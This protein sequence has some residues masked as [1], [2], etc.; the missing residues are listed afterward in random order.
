MVN[1]SLTVNLS[2]QEYT[3][4]GVSPNI[5]L[6]P[7]SYSD[8]D[9]VDLATI[10]DMFIL[11]SNGLSAA[12]TK[13]IDCPMK[14]VDGIVHVRLGFFAWPTIE[15]MSFNLSAAIGEIES[16]VAVER[17]KDFDVIFKL[18]DTAD[19]TYVMQDV[20]LDW[21]TPWFDA[22]GNFVSEPE[23]TVDGNIIR[24]SKPVFAVAR[25]TG[26]AKGF[27]A[28]NHMEFEKD[29]LDTKTT[30]VKSSVMASWTGDDNSTETSTLDLELPKC[31]S[32]AL[33]MCEGDGPPCGLTIT[34]NIPG[35]GPV[36]VYY[37]VCDGSILDVRLP[38]DVPFSWCADND[39]PDSFT[40]VL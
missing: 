38:D 22:N 7:K 28:V 32:A 40:L 9:S 39:T 4:S 6:E 5:L 25:V 1:S 23:Y 35:P 31:V 24:L 27:Y 19:L 34:T 29:G 2:K 10:Y 37:S 11:A 13:N 36:T 33:E 18:N 8:T 15:D 17:R 14:L 20:T 16:I 3:S 21:Q 12:G 30:N 26:K